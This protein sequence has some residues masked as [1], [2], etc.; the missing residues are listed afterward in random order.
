MYRMRQ[1]SVRNARW[2]NAIYL[3]VESAL[4]FAHPLLK[5]IGY[6]RLD[7]PFLAIEKLTKGI[8]LDS[9]NCGQCVVGS[10]GMSCPMNCPKSLRNGPCGGVRSDGSCEIE[11]DMPCVWLLA[12]EG[13]KHM[14]RNEYP[15]QFLQPPVDNRLIGTSAWLRA[16]RLKANSDDEI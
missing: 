5:R 2:L 9:Q 10:T 4:V 15:I 12:W 16:T 13:N 14:H 8:L 7:K 11:P 6:D 1:W 3:S